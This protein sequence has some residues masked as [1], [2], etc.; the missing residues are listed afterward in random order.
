MP[1]AVEMFRHL[2]KT[3]DCPENLPNEHMGWIL[4][5]SPVI[6]SQIAEVE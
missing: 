4:V 6:G 5:A 3:D 1:K 2:A